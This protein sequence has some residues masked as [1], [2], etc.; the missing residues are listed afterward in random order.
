MEPSVHGFDAQRIAASPAVDVSDSDCV[1]NVVSS[2]QNSARSRVTMLKGLVSSLWS[3]V[4]GAGDGDAA[5]GELRA[6]IAE[7]WVYPVKSMKGTRVSETEFEALGLCQDRRYLVVT[8]EGRFITQRQ[9][10]L[11]ATIAPQLVFND[12]GTFDG[13]R[14]TAT[15]PASEVVGAASSD[16]RVPLVTAAHVGAVT[17]TVKVWGQPIENAVDQGD[18]VS[19][20][21][22]ATLQADEELRLVY[23]DPATCK[24]PVDDPGF[25]TAADGAVTGFA[26]GYP[27]LIANTASLADLNS[28]ITA[29]SAS[30]DALPMT[31]FRPNIVVTALAAAEGA[32]AGGSADPATSA[33]PLE[34]WEEDTWRHFKILRQGDTAAVIAHMEGVKRC[35]RCLVTTTDQETGV[36]GTRLSEPLAT[37][38]TFRAAACKEV[39]FGL[40]SAMPRADTQTNGHSSHCLLRASLLHCPV[41]LT[42]PCLQNVVPK[43]ADGER[44]TLRVGDVISVTRREPIGPL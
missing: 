39:M 19:A 16:I 31:R 25:I 44:G 43:P 32:G 3:A 13:L 4:S 15:K 22:V 34:A 40:V 42:R 33:K 38:S 20:W 8:P 2:R 35:G 5:P 9:R 27:M 24:R 11:L 37:L 12:D 21:L 1:H 26:D 29:A 7:L 10:P 17:R 36:Q 30:A 41:P 28:R 18:A 23:F 6:A 14:L